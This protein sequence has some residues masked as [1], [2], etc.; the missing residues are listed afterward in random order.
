[1][2]LLAAIPLPRVLQVPA[3]VLGAVV[4]LALIIRFLTFRFGRKGVIASVCLL[5]L[6]PALCLGIAWKKVERY[7]ASVAHDQARFDSVTAV[8]PAPGCELPSATLLYTTFVAADR[9]LHISSGAGALWPEAPHEIRRPEDQSSVGKEF[10]HALNPLSWPD[11]IF[12]GNSQLSAEHALVATREA[13]SW[14]DL[15]KGTVLCSKPSERP[16]PDGERRAQSRFWLAELERW[17]GALGSSTCE[18]LKHTPVD[19]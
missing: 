6:Y 10:L 8:R 9:E 18:A 1:M 5:L 2:T 19:R 16:L 15:R 3:L 12:H 14:I 13:V 17:C 11:P 4:L 7:R